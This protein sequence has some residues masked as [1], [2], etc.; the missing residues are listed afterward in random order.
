MR[1]GHHTLVHHPAAPAPPAPVVPPPPP[2]PPVGT[3]TGLAL[4]RFASLRSDEV[5]LRSGPGTRYPIDWVYKRRDL[6]VKIEREFDVW[7]LIEDQDGTKGWVHQATLIGTRTFM[8]VAPVAAGAA[9][10]TETVR[11]A[12]DDTAPIL[13][14]LKPGVLGRLVA[15]DAASPW[16]RVSVRGINGFLPRRG[17]W[18]VLPGEKI[19]PS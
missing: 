8:V 18:G 17:L 9:S 13:A 2:A 12:A 4:P 16:C 11:A 6:P 10:D 14:Y 5:N 1:G 15:C 7:R 19:G 3:S